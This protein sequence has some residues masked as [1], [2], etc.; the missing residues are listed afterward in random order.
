MQNHQEVSRRTHIFL[1]R[2]SPVSWQAKGQTVVALS[3]LEAE[4]VAC[5]DGTREAIWLKR[6]LK[7]LRAIELHHAAPI[8]CDNQGALKL[9]QS[10]VVK[11]KA[12]HIDVKHLHAHDEQEKGNVEFSYIESENNLADLFTEALSRPR[13]QM[14]TDMLKLEVGGCKENL[15]GTETEKRG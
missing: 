7:D 9:I 5:S 11:A 2:G 1:I 10:G 6:L 8:H 3:T 4:L 13:H 12:K 14:L 15:T